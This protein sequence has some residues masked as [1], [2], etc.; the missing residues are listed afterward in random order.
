MDSRSR[1]IATELTNDIR[2]LTEDI[3]TFQTELNNIDVNLAT[4]TPPPAN[5]NAQTMQQYNLQVKKLL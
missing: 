2:K 4:R 3:A 5:A 1:A